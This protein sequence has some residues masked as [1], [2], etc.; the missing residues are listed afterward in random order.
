MSDLDPY[1]VAALLLILVIG[2]TLALVGAA[3][4]RMRRGERDEWGY[5]RR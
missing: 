2:V 1:Q 5:P 4:R 3:L